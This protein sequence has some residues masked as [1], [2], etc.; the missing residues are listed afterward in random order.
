MNTLWIDGTGGVTAELLLGALVD[1][2]AGTAALQTA[3]DAVVPGATR[4]VRREVRGADLPGTAVDVEVLAR[5]APGREELER[6]LV[7]ADLDDRLRRSALAAFAHLFDALGRQDA[8]PADGERQDPASLEVVAHVLGVCAALVD[9]RVEGVVLSPVALDGAGPASRPSPTALRLAAG[10]DVLPGGP[11]TRTTTTGLALVT[12]LADRPG[13]LPPM[14]VRASGVGAGDEGGVL[15][16]VLGD[17]ARRSSLSGP[18][19]AVVVE[20]NVD[21]L[22]PRLWPDVVAALLAAGASDA[23]LTPVLMKKGRPAHTVHALCP[24]DLVDA[25]GDVLWRHTTTLG[26]RAA[27]VTKQV[28]DRTWVEVTTAAG[29]VRVKLGFR[30]GRVV[31]AM[32]EYEDVRR[33]ATDAGV[34]VRE[35]L[36]Q[37]HAAAHRAGLVPGAPAP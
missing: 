24:P 25:V 26:W 7:G 29:P 20:A 33:A 21:D 4:L 10:W 2:G 32:P 11:G 27:A 8:T 15:Q 6:A 12:A 34:P 5:R 22:D 23:W 16:V 30:E 1:A 13:G 18:A 37:A 9:L 17:A 36:A 3:V 14:R 31:Q 35:V 28:L 19:H